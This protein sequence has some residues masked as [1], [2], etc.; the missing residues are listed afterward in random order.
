MMTLAQHSFWCSPAWLLS[1]NNGPETTLITM[2]WNTSKAISDKPDPFTT[3]TWA[4]HLSSRLTLCM[5]ANTRV[6]QNAKLLP[7]VRSHE[8]RNL[9]PESFRIMTHIFNLQTL[10]KW[11][12]GCCTRLKVLV[13]CDTRLAS[14]NNVSGR[15]NGD[16]GQMSSADSH[17]REA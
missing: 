6:S 7:W 3:Q 10:C 15:I 1:R 4:W 14:H 17:L 16:G 2:F 9:M 13:K 12:D 11:K 8:I 5:R